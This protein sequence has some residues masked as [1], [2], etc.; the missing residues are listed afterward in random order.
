MKGFVRKIYSNLPNAVSILGVLPLALLFTEGGFQ[1]IIPLIVFNNIMDDL[2]GILAKELNLGSEFG[3]RMDNVADSIAHTIIVFTVSMHF[4]GWVL[5]LSMLPVMAFMIRGV[6][7]LESK[8]SGGSATNELIRHILF[9]LVLSQ[10]LSFNASIFLIILFVIHTVTMLWELPMPYMIRSLT[11]NTF[12]IALVNASLVLVWLVP[13]SVP[14]IGSAFV[15]SY[16][17]S[18]VY[19]M[20]PGRNKTTN[21]VG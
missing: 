3:A 16:L 20:V 17:V 5:W 2:D 8:K 10:I 13:E 15:L 21:L 4:G 11:K 1:Y 6:S 18:V 12:A 14:Y 19:A 7:R 9:V